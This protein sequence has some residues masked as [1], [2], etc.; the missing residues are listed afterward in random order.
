[1]RADEF[2]INKQICSLNGKFIY[3]FFSLLMHAQREWEKERKR[4]T[5]QKFVAFH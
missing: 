3:I 5:K 2:H 1:M 4:N